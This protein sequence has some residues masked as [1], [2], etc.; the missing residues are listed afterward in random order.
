MICQRSSG[1]WTRLAGLLGLAIYEIQEVWRGQ[2]KLGQANYALR[3]L[4]KGLKFLWAVLPSESPNVMGLVGIMTQMAL[5]HFN[6]MTYCPVVGRR[7]TMRG[8]SSTTF[9]WWTTGSAWCA[10]NV[11]TTCQ[12][13]Q[14]P[15]TTRGWQNCQPSEEETPMSQPHQSNCQQETC[16]VN[17]LLISNLNRG[18]KGNSAFLW[19][20]YQQHPCPSAQLWRRT[21]W[22]RCHLP[23]CN[24]PSPVFPHILTRQPP[25]TPESHKTSISSVGLYK[26]KTE[27]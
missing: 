20:P 17:P 24:G 19:L 22:R 3:S 15:S 13:H 5:C 23:T 8:Q 4:P 21:R 10:T 7:A 12:P 27:S 11:T 18:V 9:G 16:R 6:G 2:D 25:A 14:M 1:I 26:L